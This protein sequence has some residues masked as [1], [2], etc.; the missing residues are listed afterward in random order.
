M[1]TWHIK[2]MYES[3]H[4]NINL[5]FELQPELLSDLLLQEMNRHLRVGEQKSCAEIHRS[6]LAKK[7]DRQLS[8]GNKCVRIYTYAVPPDCGDV[9]QS[10]LC[11]SGRLAWYCVGEPLFE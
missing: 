2:M 3:E 11:T 9:S 8:Q 5:W 1:S 7:A 4:I 6:I 10:Q